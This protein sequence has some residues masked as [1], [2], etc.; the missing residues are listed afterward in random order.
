MFLF[1]EDKLIRYVEDNTNVTRKTDVEYRQL[2]N[3]C[4]F[5]SKNTTVFFGVGVCE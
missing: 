2:F 5:G 3:S 1:Y 4:G